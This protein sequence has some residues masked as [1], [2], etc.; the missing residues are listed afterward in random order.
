MRLRMG[1]LAFLAPFA[2][3]ACG[4]DTSS[5]SGASAVAATPP[6]VT[7]K[8]RDFAFEGPAT[9]E[10]G[11]VHLVFRNE[12]ETLHHFQLVRLTGGKTVEDFAAAMAAFQP[13]QPMPGWAVF[14]GGVNPPDPGAE[15]TVTLNI[16]PGDYAVT[17]LVDTPDHIPHF[18]KGMTTGL[19]VTPS[20]S[21]PAS[22]PKSTLTLTLVDYAFGF[23]T[24][25]TAGHQ[26]IR[27]DNAGPQ[28]H[29]IALFRIPDGKTVDDFMQWA[30]T[31]EGK[32]P[33][34][35]LGGV[36]MIA[37]GG[38]AYMEVDLSPGTYL[39]LCFL[40]DSGDGRPHAEHGMVLPFQVS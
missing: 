15:A 3:I 21:P 22:A 40:P 23:A 39:A 12:G 14:A 16:E 25:P 29:E 4:G 1:L 5:D 19:T 6:V 24:P 30:M 17:C 10:S 26:V 38:V 28:P 7:F 37:A 27:V 36:P 35:S 34:S 9:I 33:G 18:A 2:V 13:G 32:M 20:S 31:Y 8:A 11:M